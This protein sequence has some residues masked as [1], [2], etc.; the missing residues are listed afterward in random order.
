MNLFR[1]PPET[2][3]INEKII[4]HQ[5]WTLYWNELDKVWKKI[6]NR[7]VAD[8]EKI[9]PEIWKKMK[10]DDIFLWLCNTVYK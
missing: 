6:K 4:N 3:K 5:T 10:F 7:T 1:N 8:L 9:P 2:D